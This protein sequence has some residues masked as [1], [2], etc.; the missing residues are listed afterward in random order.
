MPEH[1]NRFYRRVNAALANRG[2]KLNRWALQNGHVPGTAYKAARGTRHG[3]ASLAIRK[4]LEAL[5]K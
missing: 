2:L 1:A 5:L 4:Q 3:R